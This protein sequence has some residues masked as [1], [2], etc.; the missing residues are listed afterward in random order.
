MAKSQLFLIILV[1]FASN[2][3]FT[4]KNSKSS[5]SIAGNSDTIPDEFKVSAYIR[6]WQIPRED[7]KNN[8]PYWNAEMIKGEYLTDLI[9]AFAN[10]DKTDGTSIYIPELRHGSPRFSNIW[11]E[12]AAVKKKYPN[13]RVNISV[14]GWGA[15]GF[16]DMADNSKMRAAFAAN[17]CEWLEKYNLD[18]VDIDWEYPVG[19]E[20]GQ[21][22]KSRPADRSNYISLLQDLRKAMD[23]LGKKTG[24]RYGLSTAVPASNWFVIANDV[25]AASKIADNLKLMA[26]DY[27]GD[28]SNITGH[29]SNLYNNP[30]D[31]AWGGWSTDKALQAY[32]K[33]GVPPEKIMLGVAFYGRA[34]KGVGSA[35]NGLFQQFKS[36]AFE[37]GSTDWAQ[38]KKLIDSGYTR[39]WDDI[40]KAP[41][42]YNGD[43]WITY[44]DEEQIKLLLNYAKEKKLGG[45]FNW[46]YG[47]DMGAE[48]L[49]VLSEGI[50]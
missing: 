21:E 47:H 20:W 40:A 8:N 38:I 35:N 36:P 34:F 43:I 42:L 3:W 16:S 27:Y 39:Y 19:P 48:L 23:T 32:L 14:G 49:K 24:K 46:E 25:V 15:E 4:C 30:Q 45:V 10:I 12:V 13:L 6:T 11:N 37:D 2:L 5:N 31:P 29:H 1:L 7:Q 33:A 17:V 50:K 26:Y 28:W 44:T 41:Y 18:G 9:I 22:I